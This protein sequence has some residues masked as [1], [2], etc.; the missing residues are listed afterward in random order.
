MSTLPQAGCVDDGGTTGFAV[1]LA[2]ARRFDSFTFGLATV[3]ADLLAGT[4]C[5]RRVAFSIAGKA[6]TSDSLRVVS[7]HG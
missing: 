2:L 5:V 3:T 1:V 6:G 7:C 4:S